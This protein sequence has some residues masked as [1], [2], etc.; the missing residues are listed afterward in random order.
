MS[1]TNNII[2]NDAT[3][4]ECHKITDL[5]WQVPVKRYPLLQGDSATWPSPYPGPLSHPKK[6]TMMQLKTQ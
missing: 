5:M 1:S 4:S 6:G 2:Y 3:D